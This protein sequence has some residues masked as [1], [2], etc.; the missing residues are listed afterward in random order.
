MT[1]IPNPIPVAAPDRAEL[2]DMAKA[3]RDVG[4]GG[5]RMTAAAVRAALERK[6]PPER[7]GAAMSSSLLHVLACLTVADVL[8]MV[9][10]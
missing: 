7:V 6:F 8:A 10:E 5:K 2:I 9:E 1:T 4:K 3:L